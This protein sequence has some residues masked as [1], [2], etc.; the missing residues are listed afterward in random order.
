MPTL[1]KILK[2]GNSFALSIPYNVLS[3]SNISTSEPVIA[4]YFP[5][6]GKLIITL[7]P[8]P[9]PTVQPQPPQQIN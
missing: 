6:D 4:S 9:P 5:N 3:A 7:E 1:R 8:F 2:V